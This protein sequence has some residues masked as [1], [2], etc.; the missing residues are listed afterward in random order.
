MGRVRRL[1]GLVVATIVATTG[2]LGAQEPIQG[3][4][5]DLGFTFQATGGPSWCQS[6]V[7]IELE[8]ASAAAYESD[9]RKLEQALGRVR[10]AISAPRECPQAVAIRIQA[11]VDGAKAYSAQ[12]SRLGRWIVV[13]DAPATGEP[14]CLAGRAGDACARAVEAYTLLR[15]ALQGR[16]FADIQ[17]TRFLDS[18]SPV[19]AEWRG[20]RHVG[21]I[22]TMTASDIGF[23]FLPSADLMAVAVQRAASDACTSSGGQIAIDQLGEKTEDFA[24]LRFLCRGGADP[25]AGDLIVFRRD[26]HIHVLSLRSGVS[27]RQVLTNLAGRVAAAVQRVPSRP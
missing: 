4:S 17:L 21:Q 3:R 5:A 14:D 15:D 26:M 16:E 25:H 13:W 18:E 6:V 7:S 8:A 12:M 2:M 10:A 20:R 11:K 1:F 23:P 27:D 22:R 24:R 19:Q 9:W